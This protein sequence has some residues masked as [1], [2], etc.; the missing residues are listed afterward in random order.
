MKIKNIIVLI[1]LVFSFEAM[2]AQRHQIALGTAGANFF[3]DAKNIANPGFRQNIN[4][5]GTYQ[6]QAGKFGF[7][8][9]S[10]NYY[11]PYYHVYNNDVLADAFVLERTGSVLNAS[12][13]YQILA[14]KS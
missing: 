2:I 13:L 1:F 10:V 6:Y 7:Q 5:T 12:L 8:V 14:W 3:N 4:P 9:A 11:F